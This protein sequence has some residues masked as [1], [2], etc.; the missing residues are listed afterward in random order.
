MGSKLEIVYIVKTPMCQSLFNLIHKFC[1]NKP[2]KTQL[3]VGA[4]SFCNY[5]LC[6]VPL[7][8]TQGWMLCADPE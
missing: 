8:G 6:G 1:F 3:R 4:T 2:N 5:Y 7:R